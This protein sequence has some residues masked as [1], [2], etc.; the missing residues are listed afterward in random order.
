MIGVAFLID[1]VS[2]H[3]AVYVCIQHLSRI[4]AVPYVNISSTGY[5]DDTA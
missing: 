2:D 5:P 4:I 1:I 3:T